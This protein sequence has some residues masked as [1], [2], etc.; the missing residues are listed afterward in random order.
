[1][2]VLAWTYTTLKEALRVWPA[3][4]DP[5]SDYEVHLDEIMGLGELRAVR[6]LNLEVFDTV[7]ATLLLDEGSRI[8][9]KPTGFIATRSLR[10]GEVVVSDVE[11]AADDDSICLS[12]ASSFALEA[13]ALNGAAVV[14][15]A[16]PFDPVRQV[17]VTETAD[18]AGGIE[19]TITGLDDDGNP[20]TEVLI[21]AGDKL[22]VIGTIRWSSVTAVQT[23]LG[24]PARTVK[25][26]G[27][28][29][30]GTAVIGK[31]WPLVL[32]SKA[33]C[34]A[35]APDA[36]RV[37]RP[38]YFNERETSW[39]VVDTADRDYAV[40]SHHVRRPPGLSLA[41]P[42]TWLGTNAPDLLLTACLM[43]TEHF[44]KADDRYGDL[45]E[46]YYGSQ[47]EPGLLNT[48]RTELRNLIR[49]GDRGPFQ[50]A[51]RPA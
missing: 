46:K 27:A 34:D 7:D 17:T 13:L 2:P 45:R 35:Y 3:V 9:S 30:V 25:V 42:T 47:R 4:K 22:P 12:Q 50:S 16:V 15:S 28:V 18:S 38:K 36:R 23:R 24:D 33:F 21:T 1:M 40:I 43:E 14:A 6:D 51:M 44:L 29:G 8:V 26:G 11:A 39:E 37:K 5:E 19:V 10:I 49:Q 32:R 31:T 48:A 41:V 20:V